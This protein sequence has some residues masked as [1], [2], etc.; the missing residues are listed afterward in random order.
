MNDI[1]EERHEIMKDFCS[2]VE[3]NDLIKSCEIND[4]GN[5]GNFEIFITP[6]NIEKSTT[7]RLKKIVG[8]A[9]KEIQDKYQ[10]DI[11]AG[12]SVR[13]YFSPTAVR[14]WSYFEQKMMLDGYDRQYWSFDIDFSKYNQEENSFS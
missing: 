5:F 7:S 14:K 10:G 3:N 11:T 8:L 2:I 6:H 13:Q 9:V 4:F 12:L 1:R